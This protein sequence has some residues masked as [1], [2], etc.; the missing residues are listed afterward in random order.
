MSEEQKK[1]ISESNK[2]RWSND[3]I[4]K[5]KFCT[6]NPRNKKIFQ[7]TLDGEFVK[8]HNSISNAVKELNAKTHTNISKC[9]RGLRKKA[10]GYIWK[11]EGC[12]AE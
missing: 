1:K 7:Y 12:D 3:I 5:E 2:K 6:N 8:M 4:R 11:Y 9:A 10:C